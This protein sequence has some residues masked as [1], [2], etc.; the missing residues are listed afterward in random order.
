[1]S[2]KPAKPKA[3]KRASKRA[4]NLRVIMEKNVCPDGEGCE[5]FLDG[6]GRLPKGQMV[7]IPKK[8]A[9]G[10]IAKKLA[11]LVEKIADKA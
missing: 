8:I 9:D 4:A 1:M 3:T 6:L 7:E 2:D 11:K 10:L 5:A